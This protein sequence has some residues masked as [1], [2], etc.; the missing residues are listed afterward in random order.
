MGVVIGIIIGLEKRVA[1]VRALSADRASAWLTSVL[2]FG[3]IPIMLSND[4]ARYYA[5]QGVCDKVNRRGYAWPPTRSSTV[6]RNL[7]SE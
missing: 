5:R 6:S 3:C 1:H 7:D 4:T 2:V